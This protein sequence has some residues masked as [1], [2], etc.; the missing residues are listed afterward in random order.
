[1]MTHSLEDQLNIIPIATAIQTFQTTYP[2]SDIQKLQIEYEG[3]FIKYDIVGNDG[4]QRNSLELNGQTGQVIKEKQKALKAKDQDPSRRRAKALNL[5]NLMPLDQINQIALDN[6]NVDRPFQWEMDREK[7][8][9]V[10]KVE[11]SDASG[12]Q[13]TEVKVDAQDG[14]VVQMKLKR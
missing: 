3:P 13:V 9:T 10:W 14:T 7:D 4:S 2:K 11:I 6:A 1:M 8:R 12:S 5:D